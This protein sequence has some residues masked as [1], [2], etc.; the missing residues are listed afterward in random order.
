MLTCHRCGHDSGDAQVDL[1][2]APLPSAPLCC[3]RSAMVRLSVSLTARLRALGIVDQSL[4]R[5][6]VERLEARERAEADAAMRARQ[7]PNATG[8]Q[9]WSTLASAHSTTALRG[10]GDS[11]ALRP[12]RPHE[13]LSSLNS[14]MAM[15][16]IDDADAERI[17]ERGDR[18]LEYDPDCATC[19]GKGKDRVA[20][21]G[22]SEEV[23]M[24]ALHRPGTTAAATGGPAAH[25]SA[26]HAAS[27]S[28]TSFS[29]QAPALKALLQSERSLPSLLHAQSEARKSDRSNSM[30]SGLGSSTILIR[31]QDLPS[32]NPVKPT[33]QRMPK[34]SRQWLYAQFEEI[35]LNGPAASHRN[36]ATKPTGDDSDDDDDEEDAQLIPRL[37]RLDSSL[38]YFVNLHTL[39][40]S[41]NEL[42]VLEHLPS[43]IRVVHAAANRITHAQ[44]KPRPTP[45]KQQLDLW[46]QP[47]PYQWVTGGNVLPHAPHAGLPLSM[48]LNLMHLGLAYNQFQSLLSLLPTAGT[49]R[50]LDVSWNHL[51]DLSETTQT[52]AQFRAL[53]NLHLAGNPIALHRCYRAAVLDVFVTMAEENAASATAQTAANQTAPAQAKQHPPTT[54]PTTTLDLLDGFA[55]NTHQLKHADAIAAAAA[56]AAAQKKSESTADSTRSS[57][58]SGAAAATDGGGAS[59]R[60]SAGSARKAAVGASAS[61]ASAAAIPAPA[62]KKGKKATA[63]E[64]A[65]AAEAE[66]QAALR[67]ADELRRA[68]EDRAAALNLRPSS[69]ELAEPVSLLLIAEGALRGLPD[70]RIAFDAAYAP[71]PAEEEGSKGKRGG[72][73]KD[74]EK[75]AAAAASSDKDKQQE[76]DGKPAS[77][78]AGAAGKSGAKKSKA[79]AAADDLA[80]ASSLASD[81]H[82]GWFVSSTRSESLLPPGAVFP[83][84]SNNAPNA[85]GG[86]TVTRSTVRQQ[87][88]YY[89]ELRV[90]I[91]EKSSQQIANHDGMQLKSAGA[92][93]Q[94]QASQVL[95]AGNGRPPA[96]GT[97]ILRSVEYEYE[98]ICGL[99]TGCLPLSTL[100]PAGSSSALR[101][102]SAGVAFAQELLFQPTVAWRDTL[103][104]L[105][106]DVLLYARETLHEEAEATTTM[107][108]RPVVTAEQ[109]AAAAAAASATAAGSSKDSTP[110]GTRRSSA[111]S[112]SGA[113]SKR[114]AQ[115]SSASKKAGSSSSGKPSDSTSKRRSKKGG[116][117][118]AESLHPPEIFV[119]RSSRSFTRH[120]LLGFGHVDCAPML[121]VHPRRTLSTHVLTRE[122]FEMRRPPGK[123]REAVEAGACTVHHSSSNGSNGSNTDPSPPPPAPLLPSEGAGALQWHPQ[124][125]LR[126]AVEQ[127]AI[128]AALLGA[129]ARARAEG[130]E[131]KFAPIVRSPPHLA[132]KNQQQEEKENGSSSAV[133]AAPT[134]ATAGSKTKGGGGGG[135]KLSAAERDR[136]AQ[137]AAAAAAAAAAEQHRRDPVFTL[138][139]L[140]ICLNCRPSGGSGLG[141]PAYRAPPPEPTPEEAAAA[142]AATAAAAVAA[143]S[144][145]GRK[146]PA[147]NSKKTVANAAAA[148]EAA[149]PS[150]VADASDV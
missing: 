128:S 122:N 114:D 140:S 18:T 142:A 75:A 34:R 63:Q 46:K 113:G 141:H 22:Y 6:C 67:A 25:A 110:L 78:A 126:L 108:P 121:A 104:L 60:S 99:S 36:R 58:R 3:V 143:A 146:S 116:G 2:T 72:A 103:G 118:A 125:E 93:D 106:L 57:A 69:A 10:P 50:S 127:P 28:L 51:C 149:A 23:E 115:P 8:R 32:A 76:K 98:Q 101:P 96:E 107:A 77:A 30:F 19:A 91:A 35:R 44:L 13:T 79:A 49:L 39:H 124:G 7:Q 16:T 43:S 92:D 133:T 147:P 26:G 135:G 111:G 119:S 123:E 1:S 112:S 100:A 66:R 117:S 37:T 129:L 55:T 88:R 52:L 89:I 54:G 134:T 148:A 139:L 17:L 74:K 150:S 21:F 120:T 59:D 68:E 85:G 73:A 53:T 12:L 81:P 70:P 5:E 40:V 87:V 64:L 95:N 102:P 84:N 109:E 94:Q 80:A 15:L 136:L 86:T 29:P 62:K 97:Q 56:A 4:C 14:G 27:S 130:V 41:H 90:P 138:P 11:A 47:R 145:K 83:E 20:Q 61:A 38:E 132:A 31:K 137:E 131:L 24:N 45:T 42:R 65:E 71:A 144:R 33:P 105:G 9:M 82:K 48:Y